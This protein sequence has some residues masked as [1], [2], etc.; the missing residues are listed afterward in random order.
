MKGIIY[1][2]SIIAIFTQCSSYGKKAVMVRPITIKVVD[3]KTNTP[4]SR[5]KVYRVVKVELPSNSILFGLIPSP[6]PPLEDRVV[7]TE[8]G[9]TNE[10]GYIVFYSKKVY[11]RKKGFLLDE[12]IYINIEPNWEVLSLENEIKIVNEQKEYKEYVRRDFK[13][14]EEKYN[15][16]KILILDGCVLGQFFSS[17]DEKY[18][19]NPNN[20]Y[21]GVYLFSP[22]WEI[23]T[24]DY[25]F[26]ERHNSK[27]KY[28]DKISISKGI[29]KDKENVVVKLKRKK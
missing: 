14:E 26:D 25:L 4:L 19:I 1:I 5:I 11:I 3:E 22:I 24:E 21:K 6:S 13:T 15:V 28:F 20:T 16:Y 8:E 18:L 27:S 17:K 23:P 9:E 10:D 29:L 2:M 12:S 7:L